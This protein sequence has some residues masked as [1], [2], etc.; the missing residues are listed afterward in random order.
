VEPLL[1]TAFLLL[2]A[3]ISSLALGITRLRA[4]KGEI[5]F[6]LRWSSPFLGLADPHSSFL[7]LG[8]SVFRC[9][10]L[11]VGGNR[12]N[13]IC[14]SFAPVDFSSFAYLSLALVALPT[15]TA[16]C[17]LPFFPLS[18]PRSGDSSSLKD[19]R[20]LGGSEGL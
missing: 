19:L 3:L 6:T 10:V 13:P 8:P 4:P 12:H 1:K 9:A 16:F 17:S 20:T 18:F 15:L 11:R 5:F 2:R 14:F 7:W